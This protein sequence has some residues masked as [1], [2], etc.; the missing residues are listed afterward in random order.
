MRSL[1]GAGMTQPG[2]LGALDSQ[3]RRMAWRNESRRP[4]VGWQAGRLAMT[5]RPR[6]N[7]RA[8]RCIKGSSPCCCNRDAEGTAP[9]C[10]SLVAAATVVVRSGPMADLRSLLSTVCL[11]A[12][13]CQDSV[14]ATIDIVFDPCAPLAVVPAADATADER[15]SI[16]D[17]VAM[18][19]DLLGAR[20]GVGPD[21]QASQIPV[22]FEPAPLVFYGLYED[23]IGDVLINRNLADRGERAIVV[24][25]ELGHAFGLLHVDAAE[26]SSLMNPSNLTVA[27]TAADG[28]AVVAVWGV[29]AYGSPSSN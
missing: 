7:A 24:A 9:E 1:P 14:D 13:G 10:P 2:R 23:E 26:R 29:C 25:H 17:A 27:A 6:S 22:R 21:A 18:W 5:A 11:L 20:I 4:A 19:N 28:A 8:V 3:T 16:E 12:L 15:A